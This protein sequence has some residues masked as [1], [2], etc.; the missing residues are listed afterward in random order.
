MSETKEKII[1]WFSN[2]Q[3]WAI[4][5]VILLALGIRL[6][7]FTLTK[8]QP[9]W[10]DEAEYMLKAKS[11]ALGTPETGW[12]QAVRPILF[13]F[14]ASPF[15][16]FGLGEV[17]LRFLLVLLSVGGIFLTYLIGKEMFNKP[18]GVTAAFLMSVF[19]I[20]I[21]YTTRLL[22][23]V[24]QIF[25][26]TLSLFLFVKYAF[27]NASPKLAW[28]ILPVILIGTQMRFTVGL[29]ALI[30]GLFLFIIHGLKLF[31]KKEWY[32]SAA[33]ALACSAPYL[34]Y[35]WVRF[36]N[37]FYAIIQGLS[38]AGSSRGEGVSAFDI[39]MQYISYFPNYT[40][41]VFFVLFL[42]GLVIALFLILISFD[43]IRT[44]VISQK[45]L[46]LLLLIIVPIIYFG[47]FVNHFEDRYIFMAFPAIFLITAIALSTIYNRLAQ[48]SRIAI[49]LILIALLLY[50]GW[51]SI[52]RTDQLIKS[53]INT[54]EGLRDAGLWIKN[55]S[56]PD[57]AV[58]SAGMPEITYSSERSTYSYPA[59]ESDFLEF[60]KEK[61]VR[62]LV[63]SIW[64]SSP[65][66]TYEWPPNN[67][68]K[69]KVEQAF[70]VDQDKKQIS[71]IIYSF[72]N[73]SY[74]E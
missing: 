39:F 73:Q 64:E 19:Y 65:Q 5:A 15:F 50:G 38:S 66:W 48:Y 31:K 22:V 57:E 45:Y 23:D 49:I 27:G 33:I 28:T 41:L 61:H 17:P 60:A 40:P 32:I 9:L 14:L 21:F 63:L 52:Q 1:G 54:Y 26:V 13:P 3:N 36:N 25:F 7:Y 24:P 34:I 6:Y 42:V 71:S 20:D 16:L 12:A 10:W 53:K 58:I 55:N 43:K 72:N 44:N 56:S 4:I 69:I 46:L 30:L 2:K 70:F 51:A 68:D 67:Q 35:S 37:P 18:V 29:L 59:N 74:S 8:N 62:Y 47:F 11:I